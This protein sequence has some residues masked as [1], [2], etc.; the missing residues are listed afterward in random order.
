[1]RINSKFLTLLSILGL[2]ILTMSMPVAAKNV[3]LKSGG[4]KIFLP[5]SWK[6]SFDRNMISTQSPDDGVAIV[7]TL[8]KSAQ[9]NQAM[10]EAEASILDSVGPL[11]PDGD[12]L[13]FNLNGMPASMQKG[14]AMNGQ[15]SVSLTM[16]WT[17]NKRWLMIVYV[18]AKAQEAIW[19]S[20][21]TDILKRVRP[22]SLR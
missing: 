17:P 20:Y 6:N 3:A 12:V 14:L 19:R 5:D 10:Q 11:T 2:C 8:L 15:T 9:L 22:L 18:G 21:L 16:I 13:N 4:V 1:M 7:F